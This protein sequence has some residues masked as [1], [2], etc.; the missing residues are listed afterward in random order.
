MGW[1]VIST[2]STWAARLAAKI[3]RPAIFLYLDWPSLPLRVSTFHKPVTTT[4][5]D[6]SPTEA[7]TWSGVGNL[8]FV[9]T[10]PFGR[11][12][13]LV[14]YKAGVTSIPQGSITESTEAAAIGRRAIMYLGLFDQGWANPILQRL[15]IGHIISAGDFKHSRDKT[16][17]WFTQASVEMSNGRSPRRRL[18]NHHSPETAPTGETAWRLLPTA[19]RSVTWP[20]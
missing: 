5:D 18:G 13:A 10:S 8:G 2:D 15:F 9:E 14:S 6:L 3:I 12:G 1:G 17:N 4:E 11:N 20:S 19:G 7:A 16:G